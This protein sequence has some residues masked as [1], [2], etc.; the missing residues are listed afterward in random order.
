MIV[1]RP[2]RIGRGLANG[3]MTGQAKGKQAYLITRN[4]HI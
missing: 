2:C 4:K 1:A 3:L